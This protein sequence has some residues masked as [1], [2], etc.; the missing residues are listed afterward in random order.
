MF[1]SAIDNVNTIMNQSGFIV[2]CN[3]KEEKE[4]SWRMDVVE[5]VIAGSLL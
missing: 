4:F 1:T 2:W 5:N 3:F